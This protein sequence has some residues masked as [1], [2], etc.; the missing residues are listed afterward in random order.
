MFRN[1]SGIHVIHIPISD[2][3]WADTGGMLSKWQQGFSHN[4][5]LTKQQ[6]NY[7]LDVPNHDVLD[8]VCEL[9]VSL[10]CAPVS[11]RP[12]VIADYMNTTG[13]LV[14]TDHQNHICN[15]YWKLNGD[16]WMRIAKVIRN[17]LYRRVK[18]DTIHY[19]CVVVSQNPNAKFTVRI[20]CVE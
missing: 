10:E 11:V 20:G 8:Y 7:W 1:F 14:Y 5:A 9:C 6:V 2:A 12:M 3:E 15:S 19:H 4:S 13:S 18:L 16:R 17:Y